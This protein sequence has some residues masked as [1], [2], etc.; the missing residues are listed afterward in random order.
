MAHRLWYKS[1][2]WRALV[3]SLRDRPALWLGFSAA[4]LGLGALAAEA[5]M[6]ASNPELLKTARVPPPPPPPPPS[7]SRRRSA[8]ARA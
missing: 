8:R 6:R 4:S 1:A 3:M 5:T 2:T 7:P